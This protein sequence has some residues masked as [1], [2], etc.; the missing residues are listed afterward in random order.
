MDRRGKKSG[1]RVSKVDAG[2]GREVKAT[3]VPKK[4]AR[5]REVP[6]ELVG[7]AS[8]KKRDTMVKGGEKEREGAI[9]VIP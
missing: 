4:E 5:S 8:G 2:R 7:T 6:D 3:R 1:K 9:S